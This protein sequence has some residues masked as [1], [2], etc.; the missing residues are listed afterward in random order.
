M[1]APYLIA[2]NGFHN[3]ANV[4]QIQTHPSSPIFPPIFDLTYFMFILIDSF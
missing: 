2:P 4:Y 1:A 3:Y